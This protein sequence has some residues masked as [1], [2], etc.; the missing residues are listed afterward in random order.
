[1]GSSK[2]AY[3]NALFKPKHSIFDNSGEEE[4]FSKSLS[5]GLDVSTTTMANTPNAGPQRQSQVYTGC[6]TK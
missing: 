5:G 3:F 6:P 4:E 2:Y 1:V